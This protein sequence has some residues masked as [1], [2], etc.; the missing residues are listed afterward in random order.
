MGPTTCC[1]YWWWEQE[2]PAKSSEL[3]QIQ[4][5]WGA[6]PKG[7]WKKLGGQ[8]QVWRFSLLSCNKF[9]SQLK[10]GTGER[11][12]GVAAVRRLYNHIILKMVLGKNMFRPKD[13]QAKKQ[14][15]NF[16]HHRLKIAYR[17][18]QMLCLKPGWVQGGWTKTGSGYMP[19]EQHCYLSH[20]TKQMQ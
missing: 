20:A 8:G 3:R 15:A 11:G 13:C 14:G 18:V 6:L 5:N 12:C 19:A 7:K 9:S 16:V 2:A 1:C 4:V 17:G 10:F